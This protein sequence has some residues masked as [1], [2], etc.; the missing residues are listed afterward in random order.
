MTTIETTL[1]EFMDEGPSWDGPF[2]LVEAKRALSPTNFPRVEY[3][4]NPYGGCEHGCIYCY[5]TGYTHSDPSR[6]RVVRVRRNIAERLA[7]ELPAVTGRVAIGT[8]TD[9]YQYAEGRFRLTRS[10]IEVLRHRKVP[11][12]V[13]TKSDLVTRDIDLLSDS[14]CCVSITFTGLDER[15]SRM[16]EP[17][18]PLPSRRLDAARELVDAGVHTVGL[19]APVMSCLHGQEEDLVRAILDTGIETITC[20]PLNTRNVDT[21]RLDRMSIGRSNEVMDRLLDAGRAMGADVTDDY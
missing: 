5:A 6:W 18:A 17:G 8:S 13:L 7:R 14:D 4:L 12:T 9:P 1:M 21:A 19:I 11:F 16:T 2:E 3:S 20:D 10:C 15:I